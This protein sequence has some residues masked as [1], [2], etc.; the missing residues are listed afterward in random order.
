[1]RDVE[2]Q[3]RAYGDAVEAATAGG[4]SGRAGRVRG[5][6]RGA[7]VAAVVL[8]MLVVGVLVQRR[9]GS[10]RGRASTATTRAPG[11]PVTAEL[12][13]DRTV[14]HR[15]EDVLGTVTFANRTDHVVEAPG[16][17]LPR[18]AVEIG[19]TRTDAVRNRVE[20]TDC[21]PRGRGMRFPPGTTRHRFVVATSPHVC[22]MATGCV[23]FRPQRTKVWL[24]ADAPGVGRSR[25]VPLRILGPSRP[26]FCRGADLVAALPTPVTSDAAGGGRYRVVVRSSGRPCV[27]LGAPFV[28]PTRN[29]GE[30]DHPVARPEV[31][32]LRRG[33]SASFT[34]TLVPPTAVTANVDIDL[35]VPTFVCFTAPLSITLPNGG[36]TVPLPSPFAPAPGA[37]PGCATAVAERPSNFV[38]G[39]P[40]DGRAR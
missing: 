21:G 15:G 18:W 37:P 28:T 25:P 5:V 11:A 20:T 32:R 3:L 27:L 24:L 40:G 22:S 33:A 1:M 30:A 29:E 9:D 7:L 2:E 10:D 13:L 35:L 23:P 38:P 6:L 14:V 19:R 12:H 31:I 4:S 16:T 8:A 26:P 36:G 17:C 39:S 34:V